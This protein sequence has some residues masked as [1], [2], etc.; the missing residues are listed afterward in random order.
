MVINILCGTIIPL[1]ILFMFFKKYP[2]LVILIYPVGISIAFLAN[3]WGADL[4]WQV[5]PKHENPSLSMMPYNIGYF[6]LMAVAFSYIKVKKSIKSGI[7]ILSFAITT[8]F[9]EFLGLTVGKIQYY[10]N[11]NI[12][13]TFFIYLSGFIAA[14][15]YV[16]L[17]WRYKIILK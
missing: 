4:F 12:F 8:T 14:S 9:I 13:Y 1:I 16:N 7:L 15:I 11:W 3:D 5:M 6:P 10:N 2:E 17:L